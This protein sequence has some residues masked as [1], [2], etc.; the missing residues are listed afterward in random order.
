MY[1]R[2]ENLIVS[3]DQ[4]SKPTNK[5]PLTGVKCKQRNAHKRVVLPVCFVAGSITLQSFPNFLNLSES[6]KGKSILVQ[7]HNASPF[8]KPRQTSLKLDKLLPKSLDYTQIGTLP[9]PRSLMES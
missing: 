5:G 3:G 7:R 9:E 8:S 4:E 2:D 1:L 6:C